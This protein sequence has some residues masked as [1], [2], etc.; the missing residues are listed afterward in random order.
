MGRS[1]RLLLIGSAVVNAITA[2]VPATIL[3]APIDA[4]A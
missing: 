1:I 3:A 4:S 2:A